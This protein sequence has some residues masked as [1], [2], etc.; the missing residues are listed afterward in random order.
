MEHTFEIPAQLLHRHRCI[1][2]KGTVTCAGRD[3]QCRAAMA[4]ENNPDGPRLNFALA[5]LQKML[6]LFV[7]GSFRFR[8]YRAGEIE[9]C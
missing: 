7:A 6:C 1:Q 4:D 5:A 8:Y 2:T 3:G 9:R